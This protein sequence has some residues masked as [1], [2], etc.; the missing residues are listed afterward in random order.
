MLMLPSH[1]A[2]LKNL[3]NCRQ[4][5]IPYSTYFTD[6][7]KSYG[8][9]SLREYTRYMHIYMYTHG[10]VPFMRDIRKRLLPIVEFLDV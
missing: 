7:C 1:I 8:H 6:I 10:H 3:V 2:E 5:G 9:T 4:M